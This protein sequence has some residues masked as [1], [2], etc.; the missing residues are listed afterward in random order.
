MTMRFTLAAGKRS[1]IHCGNGCVVYGIAVALA[2]GKRQLDFCANG[3][4]ERNGCVVYAVALAAG[5]RKPLGLGTIG[6]C[7]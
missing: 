2:A 6:C 1:L 4:K 7:F 5:K 3:K